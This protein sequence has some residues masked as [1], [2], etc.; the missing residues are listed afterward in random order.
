MVR[1]MVGVRVG[2]MVIVMVGVR[3]EGRGVEIKACWQRGRAAC[4]E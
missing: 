3:V 2:V 4:S 1:V